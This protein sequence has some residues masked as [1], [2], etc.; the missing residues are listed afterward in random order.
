[1]QRGK[2]T[3]P[4]HLLKRRRILPYVVGN[5][6]IAY[7]Q[8]RLRNTSSSSSLPTAP[9]T[10]CPSVSTGIQSAHCITSRHLTVCCSFAQYLQISV[11]TSR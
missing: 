1:M 10:Q 11:V 9:W 3:K 6:C 4:A 5:N 2:N 7:Q 8:R